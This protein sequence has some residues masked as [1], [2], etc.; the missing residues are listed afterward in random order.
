MKNKHYAVIR[1]FSPGIYSTWYG[2]GGAEE[3][4]RGYANA[5]FKGFASREEAERWR[6]QADSSNVKA[7]KETADKPAQRKVKDGAFL[8]TATKALQDIVAPV[9]PS[10]EASSSQ[11]III[12]TDGGCKRNPGPGGYGAVIMDG[13]SRRELSRGFR[14]TT[15]NRMELMA[16]I[17]ALQSLAG[18]SAVLLH[19]DSQYVV[20]GIEKGWAKKWRAK[21]WMRTKEE[22]AVNPDLWSELLELCERH[23]V[24]FVWVRGHVGTLENERCDSLATQAALGKEL[25]EDTGYLNQRLRPAE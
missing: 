8:S 10:A 17:A 18:S 19:S 9:R 2:P 12:Y 5:L 21:G 23:R 11:K 1:G 7:K 24:K 16:C 15:N 4:V 22:A 13:N 14:L 25:L 6:Q 20:N 3:Q